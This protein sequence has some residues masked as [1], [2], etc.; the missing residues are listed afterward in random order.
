MG[1]TIRIPSAAEI[2]QPEY[3]GFKISKSIEQDATVLSKLET[4]DAEAMTRF[5]GIL[6]KSRKEDATSGLY[7]LIS[8]EAG[9][10]G[11]YQD[12]L[13]RMISISE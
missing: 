9:S 2:Q 1:F 10:G 12:R 8:T 7:E 4:E 3:A 13:G 6:E 11:T 5:R